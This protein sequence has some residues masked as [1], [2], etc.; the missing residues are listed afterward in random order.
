M[1]YSAGASFSTWSSSH[2]ISM[3]GSAGTASVGEETTFLGSSVVGR[4]QTFG[5]DSSGLVSCEGASGMAVTYGVSLGSVGGS[6]CS[7]ESL[8]CTVI[9]ST[10][11]NSSAF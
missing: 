6:F 11:F 2:T 10:L 7:V 1:F 4:G 9:A 3:M 8:S 5:R